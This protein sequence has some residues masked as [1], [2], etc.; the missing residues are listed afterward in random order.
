LKAEVQATVVAEAV[1]VTV[2]A[3]VVE[4]VAE[5]EGAKTVAAAEGPAAEEANAVLTTCTVAAVAEAHAVAEE[6]RGAAAVVVIR[7][8]LRVRGWGVTAEAAATE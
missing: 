3:A 6:L 5:A 2:E 1:V 8:A 4:A 7:A